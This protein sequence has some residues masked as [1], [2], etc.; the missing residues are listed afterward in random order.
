M[1]HPSESPTPLRV[2]VVGAWHV[3]ARDY[4]RRTH[5]HPD[6]E[7]IAVWDDDPERG[8]ALADEFGVEYTSDLAGLLGRS[9]LDGVTVTTVDRRSP[10]GDRRRRSTPASTSSPRSCWPPPSPRPRDLLAAARAAGRQVVVSLPRLYHGY[11]TAITEVLD[12]GTLGRLTYARVRLSH[13][14]VGP[15]L[16]AGPVLRSGRGRS[17]AL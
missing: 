10:R 12:A 13:D 14:G 7:L 1:P 17:A 2:A 9:D 15:R 4:A 8:Q 11:T 5:R 16:A 3:H 6:A